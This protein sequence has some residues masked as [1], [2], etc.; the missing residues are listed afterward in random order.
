MLLLVTVAGE[1]HAAL[2]VKSTVIVEGFPS[3]VVV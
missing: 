3:E 1:A 2:E